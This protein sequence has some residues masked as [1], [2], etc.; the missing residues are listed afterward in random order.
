[1]QRINRKLLLVLFVLIILIILLLVFG[2]FG[3]TTQSE[4]AI[5]TQE[6]SRIYQTVN[7][8]IEEVDGITLTH[9][10]IEWDYT[11]RP[12][13]V[14]EIKYITIHET[15]NRRSGADASA[16]ASFLSN[17]QNDIT[18]WHYTVDDH[19]IVHHLPDNEVAWN[20][21]DGRSE[22]GGNINGIGI[23]MCVNITNNYEQTLTNTVALVVELLYTYDLTPDDVRLHA[24]F[25][26]KVCPHR[27]ITEGR[28]EEFYE[29]IRS[30]YNQRKVETVSEAE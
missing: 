29:R 1:M 25:M 9:Q 8:E 30:A 21:G 23:E 6:T 20:A 15:D 28:V 26:D 4:E 19:S 16:H 10:H 24:D 2:L 27:L 22:D 7:H 12:G 5:P 11:R 14:R 13:E 18:S 3:K 17:D